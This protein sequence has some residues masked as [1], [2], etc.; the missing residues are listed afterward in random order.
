[1]QAI[2]DLYAQAGITPFSCTI[3]ETANSVCHTADREHARTPTTRSHDETDNFSGT[4]E[5]A[6]NQ[7]RWLRQRPERAVWEHSLCTGGDDC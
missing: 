1:M 5:A 2:S 3:A 7:R 6:G 4:E